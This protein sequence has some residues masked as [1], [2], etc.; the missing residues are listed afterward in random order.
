[1]PS[2]HPL[3]QDFEKALAIIS[4]IS[5]NTFIRASQQSQR[6]AIRQVY[7]VLELFGP[8]NICNLKATELGGALVEIPRSINVL[9][10]QT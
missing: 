2:A 1:L 9:R 7:T 4:E 6:C 5:I 8:G 10:E 3:P